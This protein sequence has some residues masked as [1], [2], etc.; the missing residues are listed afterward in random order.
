MDRVLRR[1]RQVL[2]RWGEADSDGELLTAF[3]EKKDESAFA[4]LVQRHGPMVLGVCKRVAGDHHDAEDAFQAAFLVLARKARSVRPREAVG[5]FLHGVARRA[6]LKAR[7]A[8]IKRQ[9]RERS[10]ERLP[11]P[12]APRQEDQELRLLLDR[13]LAALPEAYRLPV[14]LC[15]VEGKPIK[16]ATTQLGWPQGTLA[17]RLARGR[18]MLAQRLERRG[19]TPSLVLP[20]TPAALIRSTIQAATSFAAG[21]AALAPEVAA[22]TEGVLRSMT[23]TKAKKLGLAG[24]AV[25]CLCCVGVGGL[26][27]GGLKG[28]P[29]QPKALTFTE[30]REMRAKA[31]PKARPPRKPDVPPLRAESGKPTPQVLFASGRS[32]NSQIYLMNLDGTGVRNLSNNPASECYPAWSPDGGRIAFTSNRDGASDVYVMDADGGDAK[33]VTKGSECG[34]HLYWSPDGKKIFFGRPTPKGVR[35]VAA[36]VESGKE[37]PV[38]SLQA[39]N[40]VRDPAWSPDGKKIAFTST[41]SGKGFRVYVMDADGADV[42]EI[43]A[44][45]SYFGWVHPSWSPDGRK[46]AYTEDVGGAVE[47][48][49]CDPDGKNSKRLTHLGGINTFAAWSA[50]GKQIAFQ[51]LEFGRVNQPG[52]VYVMDAD[53]GN[54]RVVLGQDGPSRPAWRPPVREAKTTTETPRKQAEPAVTKAK[55]VFRKRWQKHERTCGVD[56]SPD[57]KLL[58]AMHAYGARVYEVATGKIVHEWDPGYLAVFT[59]DGKHIVRTM[60]HDEKRNVLCLHETASGKLLRTFGPHPHGLWALRI[61]PDGKAVLTGGN[62]LDPTTRLWDLETDECVVSTNGRES[63]SI[64]ARMWGGTEALA[65]TK[66][67]GIVVDYVL[68][69]RREVVGRKLVEDR[70]VAVYEIS[71][72]ELVRK[73]PLAESGKVEVIASAAVCGR[74]FGKRMA[75]SLSDGTIVV[76]DLVAGKEVCRFASGTHSPRCLAISADDRFVAACA[77]NERSEVVVWRLPDE[78]KAPALEEEQEPAKADFDAAKE[79]QKLRGKWTNRD[80]TLVI[81]GK[82]WKWGGTAGTLEVTAR[83][84]DVLS[85]DLHVTEGSGTGHTCEAIFRR[86]GDVLHYCQSSIYDAKT[87]YGP[88]PGKFASGD[89]LRTIYVDWRR[90]GEK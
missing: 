58:I 32:G 3:V 18:K 55:E 36:D 14:L 4:A 73:V 76:L 88:R 57:G 68:P 77:S 66:R 22:L 11:E 90:V 70:F 31:P 7:T 9:S 8:S 2:P 65:F 86:D 35:L 27:A 21:K 87:G 37:E 49:S 43:T 6:A 52:P 56:L 30:W 72:G 39:D 79:L 48:H 46:I 84:G 69:G 28:P 12:E 64:S 67:T 81:E 45:N 50:D 38:A 17:G 1:V 85:I 19:V 25:L 63:A 74:R 34:T 23:L 20:V 60:P 26:A 47:V 40:E 82:K 51:H 75:L 41:R 61:C 16:E 29:G 78:P 89:G 44:T 13:E 42:K 53:G 59:P 15:V 83:K 10:A 54:L 24:L 62:E 5:C 80:E 71:S 33:R